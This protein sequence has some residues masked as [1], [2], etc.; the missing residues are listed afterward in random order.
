MVEKDLRKINMNKVRNTKIWNTIK[1]IEKKKEIVIR[2]AD[3]GGSLVILNKKDYE[4]E[5]EKLLKIPNTYK[6]LKGNPK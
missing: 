5:M 3:K 6:R 1:G 2:P 4:L